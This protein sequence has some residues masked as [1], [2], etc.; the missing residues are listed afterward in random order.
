[1]IR[2]IISVFGLMDHELDVIAIDLHDRSLSS[3]ISV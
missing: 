3:Q 1:M 2:A